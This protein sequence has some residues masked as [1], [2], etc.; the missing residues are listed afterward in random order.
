MHILASSKPALLNNASPSCREQ[1]AG[2]SRHKN[3]RSV[4]QVGESRPVD[5]TP[6]VWRVGPEMKPFT[7]PQF[8]PLLGESPPGSKVDAHLKLRIAR[9]QEERR[10]EW[11]FQLRRDLELK[12]LEA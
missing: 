12:R 9:L 6:D 4:S 8:E 3:S 5:P 2:T 11:E 1:H 7:L 10:G